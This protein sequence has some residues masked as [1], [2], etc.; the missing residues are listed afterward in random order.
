MLFSLRVIINRNEN[1]QKNKLRR[2]I[3]GLQKSEENILNNLTKINTFSKM[4]KYDVM[5]KFEN[6]NKMDNFLKNTTYQN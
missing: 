1:K 2:K 4:R 6:I 3:V 5:K